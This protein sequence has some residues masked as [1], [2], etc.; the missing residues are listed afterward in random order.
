[1]LITIGIISVT[2][3]IGAWFLFKDTLNRI[4]YVEVLRLYWI[5]RDNADDHTPLIAKATMRQTAAPFWRGRG[6]QVRLPRSLTFQVGL[7]TVKVDSLE[8]QISNLGWLDTEPKK[9]R[10]WH[11]GIGEV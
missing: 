1:M 11:D 4:Q 5:T 8:S 9:L 3:M 2:L 7:L 6:V 10:R